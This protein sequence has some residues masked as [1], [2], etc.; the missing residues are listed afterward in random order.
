MTR[1]NTSIGHVGEPAA[2]LPL[3]RGLV[4]AKA[5]GCA[6]FFGGFSLLNL[7]GELYVRGFNTNN[8]WINFHPAP[9]WLA[10]IVLFLFGVCLL[11][12]GLGVRAAWWRSASLVVCTGVLGVIG[13]NVLAYYRLRAAGAFFTAPAV[14]VSLLLFVLVLFIL[15]GLACTPVAL[16]TH[17]G[18]PLLLFTLIACAV[19]FPLAQILLFGVTDYRRQADVIVVLGAKAFPD[20]SCSL[21][22]SDRV[23][24]AC[25]LYHQ[26]L[27]PRLI[28]SGGPVAGDMTEPEAMRRLAVSLGVPNAAI[29]LDAGGRNTHATVRD[30]TEIFARYQMRRV[31]VVSHFFHLPRIKM[32]YQRAGWNVYTVPVYQPELPRRQLPFLVTRE[33]AGLWTYYLCPLWGHNDMES[34]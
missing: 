24:T 8:W 3:W 7:L 6:L 10:N 2:S 22:L 15:Y 20:G 28:M 13:A 11:G 34:E 4:R 30:T 5:R 19:G 23:R 21:A 25:L 12:Y 14:P 31:L 1:L 17:W 32:A 27:A 9:A 29:L 33:V 26:G 16:P 18:R